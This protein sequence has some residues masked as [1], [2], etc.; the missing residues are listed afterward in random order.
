MKK[1]SDPKF[2]GKEIYRVTRGTGAQEDISKY[3]SFN[4]GS[5][6]Y[7]ERNQKTEETIYVFKQN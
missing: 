6:Y 2:V 1:N 4:E 3:I 5:G 7:G